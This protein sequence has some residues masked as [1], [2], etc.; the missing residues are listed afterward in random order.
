MHITN[1]CSI[2]LSTI[3]CV[4]MSLPDSNILNF[5]RDFGS[6]MERI[7]CNNQKYITYMKMWTVIK[8][9]NKIKFSKINMDLKI[10]KGLIK[11]QKYFKILNLITLIFLCK[12]IKCLYSFQILL[13]YWHNHNNHFTYKSLDTNCRFPI[14]TINVEDSLCP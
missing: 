5:P 11:K 8:C 12:L 6:W 10:I 1:R 7:N 14:G 3:L 2:I 13:I 9:G 4:V